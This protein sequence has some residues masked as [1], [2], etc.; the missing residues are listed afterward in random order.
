MICQVRL[1]V[2]NVAVLFIGI[3]VRDTGMKV[4]LSS[5]NVAAICIGGKEKKAVIIFF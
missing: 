5:G 2:E 4:L 1:F 3:I